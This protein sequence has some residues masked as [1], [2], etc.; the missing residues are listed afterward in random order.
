M[1]L[2]L[3]GLVDQLPLYTGGQYSKLQKRTG[4]FCLV[5]G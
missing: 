2:S 4:D 1:G 3:S 5:N